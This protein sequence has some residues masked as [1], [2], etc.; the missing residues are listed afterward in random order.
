MCQH[1]LFPPTAHISQV[2]PLLCER[3]D[4]GTNTAT[5][6]IIRGRKNQKALETGQL[7]PGALTPLYTVFLPLIFCPPGQTKGSKVIAWGRNHC[8]ESCETSPTS[9]I[10]V[11]ILEPW[12]PDF[13][14]LI[15]QQHIKKNHY[16]HKQTNIINK[17][18]TNKPQEVLKMLFPSPFLFLVFSPWKMLGLILKASSVFSL[19]GRAKRGRKKRRKAPRT[20]SKG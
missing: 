16:Q 3:Q 1:L 14:F 6:R 5:L 7:G 2:V 20:A 18:Q 17:K 19:A 4:W 9:F 12:C 8:I 10:L 15:N 13:Y 11:G